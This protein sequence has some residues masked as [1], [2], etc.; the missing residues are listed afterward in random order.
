MTTEARDP[1][2]SVTTVTSTTAPRSRPRW[3]IPGLLVVI[4]AAG[5]VLAG[6]ISVSTAIS[7]GLIGGMLLMH[8]GGHGG[9]GAHG[10][11]T[12]A[13]EQPVDAADKPARSGGCH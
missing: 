1:A 11:T 2:R 13:G 10:G 9:H 3:L 8:L 6:V 4:A 7:A 5:L 12:S